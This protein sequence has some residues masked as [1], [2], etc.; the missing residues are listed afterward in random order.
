MSET[1]E[2]GNSLIFETEKDDYIDNGRYSVKY[3]NSDG[4]VGSFEIKVRSSKM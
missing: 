1:I 4:S 3:L 2:P